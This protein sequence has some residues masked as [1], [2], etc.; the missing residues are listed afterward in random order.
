MT[1]LSENVSQLA[2][3]IAKDQIAQDI[4]NN[5]KFATKDSVSVPVVIEELIDFWNGYKSD[6]LD[7]RD[8]LSVTATKVQQAILD[9]GS[10]Y[11]GVS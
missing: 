10:G 6:S 1:T 4:S 8:Y 2:R 9:F 7:Y 11:Q 3:K 5:A